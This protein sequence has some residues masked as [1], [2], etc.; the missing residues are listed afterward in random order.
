MKSIIKKLVPAKARRLA[1]DALQMAVYALPNPFERIH[2]SRRAEVWHD[3]LSRNG[4]VKIENEPVFGQ[5]GEYLEQTYFSAIEQAPQKFLGRT[6][7]S[8]PFGDNQRFVW[9][10][11]TGEYSSGGTEILSYISFAD[12][13][14]QPLY[15]HP[16][17]I[18]VLQKYYGRQPYYR[19][20]PLI[21]KISLHSGQVPLTNGAFHVDH[22]R[23]ISLMLLVTD[24]SANETHMEYCVGS[25]RRNLLAEGVELPVEQCEAKARGYPIFKCTGKKG[26]LFIFDTSGF[27]RANYISN[28]TRK[29]LHLNITT[30]HNLVPFIDKN[31]VAVAPDEAPQYVKRMFRYLNPS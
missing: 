24:I 30:G 5:V 16:D 25:N 23:Q 29:M 14:C 31:E 20:Q 28:S 6:D 7:P 17:L 10:S 22:L 3:E 15:L 13:Q 26:T 12:R 1:R 4:I 8:Y 19:N 9:D 11:N 2:L 27:H 21:Q 18:Q